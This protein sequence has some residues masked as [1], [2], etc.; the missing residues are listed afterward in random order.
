MLAIDRPDTIERAAT[1]LTGG[2]GRVGHE[3]FDREFFVST[4]DPAQTKGI[5]TDQLCSWLVAEPR[6]SKF[7]LRFEGGDV[8]T[9]R[10]GALDIDKVVEALDHLN[11][12]VDRLPGG[13]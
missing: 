9:W 13:R 11:E 2:M 7:P 1:A 5:L 6:S 12:V 3:A 4:R 10:S 8:V